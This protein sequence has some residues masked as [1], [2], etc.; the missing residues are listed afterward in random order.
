M[1]HPQ[2][3]GGCRVE[4]LLNLANVFIEMGCLREARRCLESA[5]DFNAKLEDAD[6]AGRI[7]GFRGLL[8]HLSGNL[9]EADVLYKKCHKALG[10]GDNLRARSVFLKHHAD[11][12]MSM[13]DLEKAEL[14]IRES[15]SLAEAGV[16]PDLVA[17][18]RCSQS[19]L[20]APRG[21]YKDPRPEYQ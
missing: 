11:L 16:F 8:A 15:R 3:G 12:K 7:L 17:F 18:A 14:L 2:P 19:H 1:E 9:P 20:L 4:V 13:N 21:R 5:E 6:F 10:G